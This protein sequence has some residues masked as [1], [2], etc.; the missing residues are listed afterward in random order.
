[1][2][3]ENQITNIWERQ[4]SAET[5]SLYFGDLA[6][7]Y[8]RRKQAITGLTFFLASG[9]A[10]TLIAKFP[11]WLPTVLSLIA[12]VIMAYAVAVNL[13]ATIRTMAKLH[14]LWDQI[15]TDYSRLWNNI[16]DDDALREYEDLIRRERDLSELATTDAPNDQKRMGRWQEQVFQQHDLAGA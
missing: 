13:D 11:V 8:S 3:T 9:A 12:A 7:V 6:N 10:A 2:L 4:L 14:Y 1:M 5:R 16:Y 15:G